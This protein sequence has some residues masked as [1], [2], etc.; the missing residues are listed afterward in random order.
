MGLGRTGLQQHDLSVPGREVV[1]DRADL[2]AACVSPRHRHPGEEIIYV[3]EGSHVIMI[4]Q[5]QAVTDM[6]LSAVAAVTTRAGA[7][8]RSYFDRCQKFSSRHI[9]RLIQNST[10]HNL[11]PKPSQA[12]TEAVIDVDIDRR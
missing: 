8:S 10:G 11:L 2:E 3:L 7:R 4:S 1:Q 6:I 5:P 9:I 12:V